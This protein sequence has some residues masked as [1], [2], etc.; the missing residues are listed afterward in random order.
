MLTARFSYFNLSTGALIGIFFGLYLRRERARPHLIPQLAAFGALILSTGYGLY[1][2]QRERYPEAL[3]SADIWLPEWLFFLGATLL[4]GALVEAALLAV[5][6]LPIR[7]T[8]EWIAVVGQCAMPI[9]ILQGVV[10]DVTAFGR[11][12]GLQDGAAVA[13]AL[14]GFAL[15]IGW[16]M[17]RVHGLYYGRVP[18]RAA[19]G[20][21]L[22]SAM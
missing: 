16:M 2:L 21:Q 7:S 20:E 8:L 11:A 22:A 15:T 9:F 1:R 18:D 5:R 12:L 3:M 19:E 17:W 6:V 13:L 10:F 4:L 14:G